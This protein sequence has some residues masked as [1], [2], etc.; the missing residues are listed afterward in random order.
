MVQKELFGTV[1]FI[2][3]CRCVLYVALVAK[4]ALAFALLFYQKGRRLSAYCFLKFIKYA[5]TL[6]RLKIPYEVISCLLIILVINEK[7]K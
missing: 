7:Y 3:Y 6:K 5:S 1:S 4:V 2:K